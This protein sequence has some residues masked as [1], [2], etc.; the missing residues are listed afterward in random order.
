MTDLARIE[1][2]RLPGAGLEVRISGEVDHSNFDSVAD[3]IGEL[4]TGAA[5]VILDLSELEYLD[6]AGVRMVD[7]LAV[8]LEKER[9]P[10]KVVVAASGIC[11]RVLEVTLPDLDLA[12]P[13]T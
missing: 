12:L 4:V 9:V 6:S 10:L 8:D 11:R 5:S 13:D 2:H 1:H 7:R 3:Q